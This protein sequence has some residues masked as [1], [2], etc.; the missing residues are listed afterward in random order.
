MR[1]AESFV[2][3]YLLLV[4][5]VLASAQFTPEVHKQLSESVSSNIVYF[6]DSPVVLNLNNDQ[7]HR[8]EN[9][10]KEWKKVLDN[11]VNVQ[12]DI[13]KKER[14]FA[15]TAGTTHYITNDRGKTWDEFKV[16]KRADSIYQ[17]VNVN[18]KNPDH[19]LIEFTECSEESCENEIYY[20]VDGFKS[21][22]K[23]LAENVSSCKFTKSTES[24]IEGPDTRILC[25]KPER[26]TDGWLK[27][28]KLLSSDDFFKNTKIVT[29]QTKSLSSNFVTRIEIIHGFI[30][31]V[32]QA[33]GYDET[34]SSVSL[35][36]SKDSDLF[37]KAIIDGN[38]RSDRLT[39]L[40]STKHSLH[41]SISGRADDGSNAANIYASDSDGLYFQNLLTNLDADLLGF[42]NLDKIETIEGVW[43]ANIL[44]GYDPQTLVP[45]TRS[46]ITFDDGHTWSFLKVDDECP[47]DENCSLNILSLEERRGDGQGATGATPGL[48]LAIGDTG[49]ALGN[50]VLDLHT[51]ASR[52]GGLTW[53][54]VLDEPTIYA[55]GDLG[56]VMVAAPYSKQDPSLQTSK[57]YYSL[58]QAETWSSFELDSKSFPFLMTT[59]IDGTTTKFLYG[60]LINDEETSS[61]VLYSFD[62][63]RAFDRNCDNDEDYE[64]WSPRRKEDGSTCYFGHTDT[65]KRRK[66]D[67]KCFINKVWEDLK[68]DESPCEC[69]D[70]DFECNFGFMENSKGECIL[71]Y[72]VLKQMCDDSS[73][74]KLTL[75]TKRKVIGNMCTL[76]TDYNIDAT[77]FDC[78]YFTKQVIQ[79]SDN[80]FHGFIENYSFLEQTESSEIDETVLLKTSDNEIFISHD[81]GLEFSNFKEITDSEIYGYFLNPY[82]KDDVY[83]ISADGKI[84]ISHNRAFLFNSVDAPSDINGFNI[85]VFTFCNYSRDEFIYYGEEGCDSRFSSTC[86]PVAY[87]T[88]DSGATWNKLESNVRG[89]DFV[90]A[91]YIE[92]GVSK[93]L[94]YCLVEEDNGIRSLVSSSDFYENS[95]VEFSDI[96][97]FATTTHFTIVAA[98]EGDTLKAYVTIDGTNFAAALFPDNFRVGKQQAYTIVDSETG[99]VFLH[100]TTND[101]DGTEFGAILKSNYNGTSFVLIEEYSNRNIYGYVDFERVEGLEGIAIINTV[102]NPDMAKKGSLKELQS[103][104]T[105]NDGS[106]WEYL[107][108]PSTDS[109]GNKYECIGKPLSECSLHLHGYTERKD[110]RDTFSSG[111]AIGLLIG[112]GNVGPQLTSYNDGHTFM[113]RDGGLTWKEIKK[114]V[115][116]WEYGDRGSIIALV[117]DQ[118]STNIVYYSLDEGKSWNE[119]QFSEDKVKVNDIVTVPSDNSKK[120]LLITTSDSSKGSESKTIT[121]DFER[122]FSRQCQLDLNNPDADDFEYWT[123]Q[124][125]YTSSC[126]FGHEAKYL[127]KVQGHE[128]FIN[129]APLGDAYK[130]VRN[131]PCTRIDFECDFNYVKASDGTCKLVSGLQPKDPSEICKIDENAIEYFEPTG[132]RRVAMSTCE[133][134]QEFDKVLAKPCKGKES[135]FVDKHG[136]S[137]SGF[138]LALVIVAPILIFIFALWFVYE[139]GIRRN[140]GFQRF[141]EIRLGD[142]NDLIEETASDVVVNKIV[143]GGITVIA[144]VIATFKMIKIADAALINSVKNLF[145][146][147]NRYTRRGEAYTSVGETYR[148]EDILNDDEFDIHEDSPLHEGEDGF[149]DDI[150]EHTD[151]DDDTFAQYEDDRNLE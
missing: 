53:K 74:Q 22:A 106:D 93:D 9:D 134:G 2:K 120:F 15:F 130:L 92:Y 12:I 73:S 40:P 17:L 90:G 38:I 109:E 137:L 115:Y 151:I 139:R 60:G 33:N 89:C 20:T 32:V 105:F 29:D 14:A 30:V 91:R 68:F 135:Q 112:V 64:I 10:G 37:E 84:H 114:G 8:S 102:K 58:D 143:R 103:K 65:Y 125:P 145:S 82:F 19:I 59:A 28:V 98:I 77:E 123:P 36:V 129:N 113:T 21:E 72:R 104:I 136:G 31:A 70:S 52:D 87:L 47:G 48:L 124:H 94:V 79:T 85:P 49:N 140:G 34:G 57:I 141:G 66:P 132:Y 100:V 149:R 101:R 96:V 3:V 35:F 45:L 18:Y 110:Y 88:R 62:F 50:N 83:L 131:C 81:G 97:G 44:Q 5:L 42:L 54:K 138:R 27:S 26:G 55:F 144:A 78:D 76:K 133:G 111:S 41:I 16:G 107:A 1:F 69:E 117:D 80:S 11:I 86:K 23:K 6:D 39:F 25:L 95:K 122:I 126:L 119:Y 147:S 51:Y 63:F 46:K 118:F 127:K 148:D 146:R 13:V 56:N 108:P 43:T 150:S 7:L 24:F 67:A 75:E 4:A 121:L 61:Q 71:N 128:C 116:Q 142:D 99:A